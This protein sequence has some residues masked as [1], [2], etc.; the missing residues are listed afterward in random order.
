MT[1]FAKIEMPVAPE[2]YQRP[3]DSKMIGSGFDSSDE[4]LSN[5]TG[6]WPKILN[7]DPRSH[8]FEKPAG[9]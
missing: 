8:T 7:A 1:R 3:S 6:G 9:A 4:L 5:K 2:T